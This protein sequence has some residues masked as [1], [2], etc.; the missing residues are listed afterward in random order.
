MFR[1]QSGRVSKGPVSSLRYSLPF[2]S[3]LGT[4]GKAILGHRFHTSW[5][6]LSSPSELLTT[7]SYR[8]PKTRSTSYI[9]AVEPELRKAF[10]VK[11]TEL[12]SLPKKSV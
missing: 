3:S 5:I 10:I 8:N 4:S 12:I 6:S 2:S 11:V 7:R 1:S 9:T